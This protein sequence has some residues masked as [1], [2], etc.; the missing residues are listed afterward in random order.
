MLQIFM[1]IP[2]LISC[3]FQG[4]R[5]IFMGTGGRPHPVRYDCDLEEE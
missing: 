5:G 1:I 3:S 2:I 4:G